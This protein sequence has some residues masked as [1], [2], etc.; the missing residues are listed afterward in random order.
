[1]QAPAN[2]APEGEIVQGEAMD[3]DDGP[4][5]EDKVEW[6][7]NWQSNIQVPFLK[8]VPI[9]SAFTSLIIYPNNY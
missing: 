4:A 9:Y 3:I 1:M 8:S 2:A 5:K 6:S 7:F